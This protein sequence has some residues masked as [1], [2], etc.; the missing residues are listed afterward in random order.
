[1]GGAIEAGEDELVGGSSGTSPLIQRGVGSVRVCW[2][3]IF[4][5]GIRKASGL[6]EKK[7]QCGKKP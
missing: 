7:E 3:W 2:A 1:V 6:A 4:T 5:R